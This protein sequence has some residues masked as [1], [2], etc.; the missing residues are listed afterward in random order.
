MEEESRRMKAEA[1]RL[2]AIASIE[3]EKIQREQEIRRQSEIRRFQQ[4][5]MERRRME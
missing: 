1:D 4:I 2:E 5:E 3:R